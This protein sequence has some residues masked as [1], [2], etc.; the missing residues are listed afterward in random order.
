[1]EE[2]TYTPKRLQTNSSRLNYKKEGL[3]NEYYNKD[4]ITLFPKLVSESTIK[5][6]NQETLK[7][8]SISINL[9]N[10]TN[11]NLNIK[12]INTKE[13]KKCNIIL[14]QIEDTKIIV[15]KI[16]PTYIDEL[17]WTHIVKSNK[18]KYKE[19]K[20]KNLDNLDELIKNV[21]II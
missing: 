1:M 15:E 21:I 7:W 11:D 10:D 9:S 6:V 3:S 17:G 16:K 12:K 20:K 14:E 8:N 19:K 4:D 2:I 13:I 18:P 5:N